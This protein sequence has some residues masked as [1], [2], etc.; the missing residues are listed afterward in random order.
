MRDV[1]GGVTFVRKG[2]ENRLRDIL[3]KCD[4]AAHGTEGGAVNEISVPV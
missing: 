4:I 2:D 1:A 3:C